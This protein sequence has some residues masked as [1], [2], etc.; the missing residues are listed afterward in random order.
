MSL[1]KEAEIFKK[2]TKDITL[3]KYYVRQH[4]LRWSIKTPVI[5]NKF[6][7]NNDSS[8]GYAD[9]VGFRCGTSHEYSMFDFS[10]KIMNL[11]QIH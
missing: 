6:G 10:Q 2:L 8:V 4:Y 3:E 9:Y 11:K 7:F 5:Q 1:F